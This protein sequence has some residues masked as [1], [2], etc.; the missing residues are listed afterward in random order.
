MPTPID[1]V[2]G[3]QQVG[4][5]LLFVQSQFTH[6]RNMES[7]GE[8]PRLAKWLLVGI[9]GCSLLESGVRGAIQTNSAA[10]AAVALGRAPATNAPAGFELKEGFRM[11]LVAGESLV[12]DPGAMAFDKA[13]RLF[14]VEMRDYPDG[15]GQTPHLGRVRM[16]EDTNGDGFFDRSTVFADNL[17]QP[18]AVACYRGGVFVGAA[19]D[20]LFLQDTNG[21]GTA[22]VQRV[23]L[24]GFGVGETAIA[25]PMMNSFSWGLDNRIHAASGGLDGAIKVQD[26]AA[27]GVIPL[28]ASDFSFDANT[29]R[30]RVEPETGE[31]GLMFDSRG[32]KYV[33]AFG[34]PMRMLL[35]DS[36][37]FDRNPFFPKPEEYVEV[38][39]PGTPLLR[40]P[41]PVAPGATNAPATQTNSA[42]YINF[43]RA[44]GGVIYRGSA[45][46]PAYFDNAFIPDAVA[47][48]VHRAVLRDRGVGVAGFQPPEETNR[49]FLVIRTPW[50][51][52]VQVI[53]APDGS[54]YLAVMNRESMDRIPVRNPALRHAPGGGIYR[55]APENKTRPE[56]PKLGT[57]S[58]PELVTLLGSFNQ[59]QGDTAARLLFERH[60]AAA[61]P[62]LIDAVD[63][64]KSPL[65]R[66]RALQGL[67][68]AGV[69]AEREMIRALGDPDEGVRLHA[70]R[71]ADRIAR[72]NSISPGTW[73][74][75]ARLANDG[76]I[77]VR[78]E[79]AQ[80]LGD[81]RTAD[82][83]ALLAAIARM[84]P[85]DPWVR[86]AV[87]GSAYDFGPGLFAALVNDVGFREGAGGSFFLK[88]LATM[89]GTQ[90]NPRDAAQVITAVAQS[91]VDAQEAYTFLHALDDGLHRT[92]TSLMLLDK[93]QRLASM[94]PAR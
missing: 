47:R 7:S 82:N 19:P 3:N 30:V 68:D 67:R 39:R 4:L 9:F 78:F 36:R 23:V 14:V 92:R 46:P 21:S 64:A 35:Y 48:V 37:A 71:V 91:G 83:P 73:T 40:P 43:S 38:I 55:I 65:A 10:G 16:L 27:E 5:F 8:M 25:R 51:H 50:L 75:L 86:G 18:S 69:L 90:G 45:F 62:L 59:W 28:H 89:V 70:V 76:S 56:V 66:M 87:F 94:T 11:E 24:T 84:S 1:S 49:E 58:I 32:R 6:R 31:S 20:V 72:Q 34:R 29:S 57:A 79:V 74:A 17:A 77:C 33:S 80:T 22:D 42:Q 81:I 61:I 60:D 12:E 63:K 53:N 54:L 93:E 52:P 15:R 44:M 2:K 13:G 41:A 85:L 88:D 26:R